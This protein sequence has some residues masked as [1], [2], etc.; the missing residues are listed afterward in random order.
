MTVDE[1]VDVC[2]AFADEFVALESSPLVLE[3]GCAINSYNTSVALGEPFDPVVCESDRLSCDRQLPPQIIAAMF[4]KVPPCETNDA[5]TNAILDCDASVADIEL[6]LGA[7]LGVFA[8]L[9]PD[10][11]CRAFAADD[12]DVEVAIASL[13]DTDPFRDPPQECDAV[14][15]RCPY[16]FGGRPD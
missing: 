1:A 16:V 7:M 15:A 10:L 13:R 12:F 6:C 9:F 4:A 14:L 2:L 8:G 5:I 11:N 3:A